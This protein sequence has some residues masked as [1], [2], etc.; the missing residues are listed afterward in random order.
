MLGGLIIMNATFYLDI[1]I[2]EDKKE[3]KVFVGEGVLDEG[4]HSEQCKKHL[5]KIINFPNVE[6]HYYEDGKH[7]ICDGELV[8]IEAFLK[9][10]SYNNIIIKTF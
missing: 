10:M 4:S 2:L 1:G 6:I 7:D 8:G 5:N 9:K 3:L